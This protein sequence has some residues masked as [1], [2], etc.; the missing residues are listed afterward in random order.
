MAVGTRTWFTAVISSLGFAEQT[1]EGMAFIARTVGG[2]GAHF[3]GNPLSI[4]TVIEDR[5]GTK[6]IEAYLVAEHQGNPLPV[7]QESLSIT[8]DVID[9]LADGG[10]PELDT[11]SLAL[12]MAQALLADHLVEVAPRRLQAAEHFGVIELTAQAADSLGSQLINRHLRMDLSSALGVI[13]DSSGDFELRRLI[14]RVRAL[15]PRRG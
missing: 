13:H 9:A 7:R 5:Y 15:Q 1:G 10:F 11:E 4:T 8:R 6:V 12:G 3:V 14:S 2:P